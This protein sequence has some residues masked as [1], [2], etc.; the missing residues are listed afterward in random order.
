VRDMKDE[1]ELATKKLYKSQ[2]KYDKLTK[3]YE[4]LKLEK[5]KG[6]KDSLSL[7]GVKIS[8]ESLKGLVTYLQGKEASFISLLKEHL[9]KIEFLFDD[10]KSALH[11][12]NV[13]I[14]KLR[15]WNKKGVK[16][17]EHDLEE[18]GIEDPS[19]DDEELVQRAYALESQ[20]KYILDSI[21][22]DL[23]AFFDTYQMNIDGKSAR[24]N[25]MSKDSFAVKE[26]TGLDSIR[27]SDKEY[28]EQSDPNERSKSHD[29]GS[30]VK[31]RG[32]D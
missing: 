9:T 17:Q 16:M 5:I 22:F 13:E 1:L 32:G 31:T 25:A 21:N 29:I 4:D 23:T 30:Y 8:D 12:K 14:L 28:S 11:E 18:I 6:S 2:L 20:N 27:E 26:A 10:F 19:R 24:S 15:A 7:E 3:K